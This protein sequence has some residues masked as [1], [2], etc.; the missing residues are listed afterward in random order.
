MTLLHSYI[1]IKFDLSVFLAGRNHSRGS[2]RFT[3][4]FF[5]QIESDRFLWS[6]HKIIQISRTSVTCC[7]CRRIVGLQRKYEVSMLIHFIVLITG[8]IHLCWNFFPIHPGAR[9][10]GKVSRKKWATFLYIYQQVRAATAQ[11][12]VGILQHNQHRLG[13]IVVYF[14][15]K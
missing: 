14:G 10:T 6:N 11:A 1:M 12:T 4:Y 7:L 13:Y 8:S 15:E 3:R 5:L 2:V 9:L